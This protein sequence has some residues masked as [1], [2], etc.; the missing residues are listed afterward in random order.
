MWRRR[1][2]ELGLILSIVLKGLPKT[3]ERLL[4]I[5][6]TKCFSD[7]EPKRGKRERLSR[8]LVQ[9]FDLNPVDVEILADDEIQAHS[10]RNIGQFGA[11]IRVAARAEQLPQARA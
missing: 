6:F 10:S 7:G 11:Q 3:I 1:I 8:R 4:H 5:A 2:I 9:S